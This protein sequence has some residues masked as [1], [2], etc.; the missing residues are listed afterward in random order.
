MNC[1]PLKRS[2]FPNRLPIIYQSVSCRSLHG[3]VSTIGSICAFLALLAG[4]PWPSKHICTYHKEGNRFICE[5]GVIKSNQKPIIR[6][7][8]TTPFSH[9]NNVSRCKTKSE[10][11]ALTWDSDLTVYVLGRNRSY[12]G[13]R[14]ELFCSRSRKKWM[15]FGHIR[16]LSQSNLKI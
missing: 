15:K 1:M 6:V 9:P 12:S 7:T 3:V 13:E 14:C 4:S 10:S 11:L 5:W 2:H 16:N 8:S